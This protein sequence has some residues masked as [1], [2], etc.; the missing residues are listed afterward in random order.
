MTHSHA[1]DQAILEVCLRRIDELAYVGLIG[2]ERKWARFRERLLAK[3]FS[4]AALDKVSSPIGLVQGSKEPRAI[5][6]SVA[7]ELLDVVAK[8]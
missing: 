4:E 2:S 1:L 5:A 7:A 3:G 6:L 8:V